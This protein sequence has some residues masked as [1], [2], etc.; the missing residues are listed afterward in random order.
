MTAVGETAA[1]GVVRSAL[2][3]LWARIRKTRPEIEILSV[4]SL[5]GESGLIRFRARVISHAPRFYEAHVTASVDE[6]SV[7]CRPTV[8]DL[9]AAPSAPV[10]VFV[11][12][13]RP[14][15]GDLI[16][17]FNHEPTLY[18]MTLTVEVTAAKSRAKKVWREKV[19]TAAENPARHQIQQSEWRAARGEETED[20]RRLA[21]M[22]KVERNDDG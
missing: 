16:A 6:H 10:E 19:Y 4:D 9:N 14:G 7:D 1:V 2:N 8:F 20:D 13:P 5:G 21:F 15:L 12:V 17:S 18:G 11:E 3:A 22:K